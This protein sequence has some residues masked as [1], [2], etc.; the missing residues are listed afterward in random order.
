MSHTLHRVK[1]PTGQNDDYVILV[2]C[3]KGINDQ[4]RREHFLKYS[5][6][7]EKYNP[8]NMGAIRCGNLVDK[9]IEE[10][11]EGLNEETPMYH[12]VFSDRETVIQVMK[13]LKEK[14]LGYSVVV[15]GLLDDVACM[16]K[17]AGIQRHSV[18]VSL[19]IWGHTEKLPDQKILEITTMCG[20]ALVSAN[21]VNKMVD[22]I[23]AGKKTVHEA[24]IVLAK[25]CVCGI[26]N[27]EKAERL[28]S[29][30]TEKL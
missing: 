8:I 24:A 29:E 6:I 26:F 13:E 3:H 16:C 25:P 18:D 28:L 17:E 2:M 7:F 12:A 19:G 20:H 30:M 21:L 5:E 27:V 9:T 22:D 15:S 23:R 1:T 11:K 10:V 4:E 14:D